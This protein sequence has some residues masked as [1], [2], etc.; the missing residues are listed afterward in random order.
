M[1][2]ESENSTLKIECSEWAEKFAAKFSAS[3]SVIRFYAFKPNLKSAPGASFLG[4]FTNNHGEIF[5][6]QPDWQWHVAV[7]INGSLYDEVHSHG[8]KTEEYLNFFRHID[9]ISVTEHD[10]L[11]SAIDSAS[12]WIKSRKSF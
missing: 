2:K 6:P 1:Q 3:G 10:D 4:E 11:H 12:S 8:V 9:M 5:S 7:E